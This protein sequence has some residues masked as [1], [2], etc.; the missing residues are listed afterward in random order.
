M[1]I[2]VLCDD[3]WHPAQTVRQGLAALESKGYTFYFIEDATEWSSDMMNLYPVVILSKSNNV[4]STNESA[5]MSSEV[6]YAFNVY[7]QEGH[8]LLAIHSGTA[9]Y[10]NTPTLRR[11]LGGVFD[12]HPEQ[13]PVRVTPQPGHPITSGSGG[14]TQKDEHYFMNLDDDQADVFLVSDSDHGSQ[15]AGWTRVEG[16]GRVCVLTPGHNLPVWQEASYQT[17]LDNALQWCSQAA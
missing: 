14:F 17:L 3:H 12:H 6:E 5:W 11:L 4:S 7:V 1:K 8:G 13:C 16:L 9:G 15:P 10:Q 2:L